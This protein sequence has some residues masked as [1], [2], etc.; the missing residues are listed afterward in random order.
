MKISDFFISILCL[1]FLHWLHSHA[2]R[3]FIL[4]LISM[5]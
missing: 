1:D 2:A 4:L 3:K 5:I